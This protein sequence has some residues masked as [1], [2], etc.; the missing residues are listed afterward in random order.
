[1]AI[2]HGKLQLGISREVKHKLTN[3]ERKVDVMI[4]CEMRRKGKNV[5]LRLPNPGCKNPDNQ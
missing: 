5:I 2:T 4:I 1:M 3:Q